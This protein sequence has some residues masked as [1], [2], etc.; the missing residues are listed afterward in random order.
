MILNFENFEKSLK[1]ISKSLSLDIVVDEN[2]IVE[3]PL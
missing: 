1:E 3:K 2:N